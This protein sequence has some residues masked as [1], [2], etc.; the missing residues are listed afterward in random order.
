MAE[1]KN[2]H[3]VPQF[4]QRRFSPDG[5]TIGAY[6]LEKKKKVDAA[7]IKHQAS[8]DY[9]YTKDTAK[10]GNVEDALGTLEKFGQEVMAKID[11]DPRKPLEKQ[12]RFTLYVFTLLQ[13][14]RTMAM[15]QTIQ[16]TADTMVRQVLREEIRVK[17][18]NGDE[19]VKDLTDDVIDSV[20]MNLNNPGGFSLGMQSQLIPTC[21]DLKQKIL[22]NNTDVAFVT[23]DN[24]TALYNMY[25]ERMG[26]VETGLG[27]R[28]VFLYMPLSP[29]AAV[30]LY[31]DKVYKMGGRKQSFVE[32][33]E[34][35][36]ARELNRLTAVNSFETILFNPT[37]THTAE[38]EWLGEQSDRYTPAEKIEEINGIV[39]ESGNK[40]IGTHNVGLE[41]K[42]RL[43]FLKY[44]P[45]Y[46]AM[47]PEQFNR[48]TDLYREIAYVKDE[49]IDYYKKMHKK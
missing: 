48:Q 13:M 15:A 41:C 17:R 2:Q 43:S 22:I 36:D 23:S 33:T 9:F 44:L 39:A 19:S 32:I 25:L 30:V 27:C 7:A 35:N 24:P 18:A 4:Y 8:E 20:V 34:R 14:G 31:D 11:A 38:L 5:K 45:K 1:K 47:K 28:G 12:D 6:I 37:L 21:I 29:K 3:Y 42:L 40:I 46:A 26:Q 10:A 16:K 49:L